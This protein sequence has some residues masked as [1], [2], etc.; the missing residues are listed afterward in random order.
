MADRRSYRFNPLDRTG[1][2]F[3]MELIQLVV[4]GFGLVASAILFS[5]LKFFGV[6]PMILASIWCFAPMGPLKLYQWTPVMRKWLRKKLAGRTEWLAPIPRSSLEVKSVRANAA[7][8]LTSA[9]MPPCLDG[10]ELIEV[11]A[12]WARRT[13]NGKIGVV[14]DNVSHLITAVIPVAGREFALVDR[15]EQERLIDSWGDAI[16]PFCRDRSPVV[17]IGWSEWAAPSGVDDHRFYLEEAGRGA[18]DSEPYLA[19]LDLLEMAGPMVTTHEVLVTI[20]IDWNK[21]RP[22]KRDGTDFKSAAIRQCVEEVRLFSARLEGANLNVSDPLSLGALAQ[23]LR[24]RMDPAESLQLQARKHRLPEG[25]QIVSGD[26]FMPLAVEENWKFVRVDGAYHRAYW[27]YEWPRLEVPSDWMGSLLLANNGVRTI[28]MHYEPVSMRNSQRAV[29]RESTKI[30]ADVQT[31]E[32]HGFR[33]N[34]NYDRA[35]KAV[36]DREQEIVAGFTEF[37]YVGLILVSASS[38]EE[39]EDRCTEYEQTAA[40][41]GVDVRP[42]DGRHADGWVASLPMGRGVAGRLIKW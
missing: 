23:A 34:A 12:P 10:L 35:Q 31:R 24:A 36:L 17:R 2:L 21:V 7:V 37:E 16:A 26:N 9:A 15:R 8:V 25:T 14:R 38:Q 4:L 11:D 20:S 6:I 19:Y 30:A 18:K 42:L 33:V 28:A 40:S 22:S 41:V 39:L 29:D 5:S 32:K 13:N 3:G 27:V 1:V